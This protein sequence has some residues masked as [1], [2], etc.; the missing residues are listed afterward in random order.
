MTLAKDTKGTSS[1]PN[2]QQS[3]KRNQQSFIDA[4]NYLSTIQSVQGNF[5][6]KNIEQVTT[7]QEHGSKQEFQTLLDFIDKTRKRMDEY[8]SQAGSKLDPVDGVDYEDSV[9]YSVFYDENVYLTQVLKQIK[10]HI[11]ELFSR[12]DPSKLLAFYFAGGVPIKTH[13]ISDMM[14]QPP[15]E[16]QLKTREKEVENADKQLAALLSE[17]QKVNS[18]HYFHRFFREWRR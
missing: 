5:I 17:Y 10:T 13:P 1:T 18:S 4:K 7:K 6:Q 12:Y 15:S 3:S 11:D 2:L 8:Q 14:R 9:K 16:E